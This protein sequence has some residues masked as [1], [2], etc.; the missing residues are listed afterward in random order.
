MVCRVME[1]L[2]PL[3]IYIVIGMY[4]ATISGYEHPKLQ[5]R[6]MNLDL[7]GELKHNEL[8]VLT[9]LALP[10][11]KYTYVLQL[12]RMNLDLSGELKHNELHVL[13]L[14]SLPVQKAQIWYKMDLDLSGELQ[15]TRLRVLY[16]LCQYKSTSTKVRILTQE[17]ERRPSACLALKHA[18]FTCFEMLTPRPLWGAPAQP[19]PRTL[20]ALPVQKSTNADT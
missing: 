10:V 9:L 6:R 11:R 13:T 14:L 2:Y 3:G 17:E 20:L 18:H 8:Q 5:L 4:H 15:R 19:T 1:V 16:L 7:S 12:R